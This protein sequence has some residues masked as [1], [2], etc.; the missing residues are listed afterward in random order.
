[1]LDL[2]LFFE[3]RAR[4]LE[5]I[6]FHYERMARNGVYVSKYKVKY[7]RDI[8]HLNIRLAAACKVR[9]SKRFRD[10]LRDANVNR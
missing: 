6:L 4:E 3:A 5:E 9:L 1:M 7:T 2:K 8:L 10:A